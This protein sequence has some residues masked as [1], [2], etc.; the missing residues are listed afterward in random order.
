MSDKLTPPD[1]TLNPPEAVKPV[2]PDKAPGMIQLSDETTDLLDKKVKDFVT[3][4]LRYAR[5]E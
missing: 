3:K 2:A 1:I 4:V 5:P